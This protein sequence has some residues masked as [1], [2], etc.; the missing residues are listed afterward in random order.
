MSFILALVMMFSNMTTAFGAG[1]AW[2][3]PGGSAGSTGALGGYTW[4]QNRQF[5]RVSLYWAPKH[6]LEQLE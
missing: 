1:M 2:A 6:R 4:S 3:N 5:L